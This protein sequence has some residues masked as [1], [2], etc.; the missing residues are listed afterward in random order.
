MRPCA[1]YA[2]AQASDPRLSFWQLRLA[3]R[4]ASAAE[5]AA[6][7]P[8]AAAMT[9][10]VD[11]QPFGLAFRLYEGDPD[12]ALQMLRILSVSASDAVAMA[13]GFGACD[14]RGGRG[15]LDPRI[16]A[17]PPRALAARMVRLAER[18]PPGLDAPTAVAQLPELLL[19]AD[20]GGGDGDDE[21]LRRVAALACIP[22]PALRALVTEW[23]FLL[24]MLDDAL[25]RKLASMWRT[26]ELRDATP[27]QLEAAA[28]AP[29]FQERVA[30]GVF[31]L[32][33][34]RAT[35]K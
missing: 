30:H 6:L 31:Q 12:M 35:D 14:S 34:S 24:G 22:A 7:L 3:S 4:G 11:A 1:P 9:R 28:A 26:G 32:W 29:G 8:A 13:L 33:W 16:L 20:D 18:L 21:A 27:E 15:P 25:V 17:L 23:P 19:S 10:H 5:L 2:R